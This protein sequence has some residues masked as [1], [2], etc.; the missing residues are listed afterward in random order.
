MLRLQTGMLGT[1][2]C[3]CLMA[4]CSKPSAEAS[5]KLAEV[6]AA[7]PTPT[8]GYTAVEVTGGGTLKGTVTLV[9][10]KPSLPVVRCAKDPEICGKP[11]PSQALLLGPNNALKNV[12]VSL[13]DI[14]AGRAGAAGQ[15]HIDIKKCAYEPR[16]QAV[17]VKSNVMVTN[18]DEIPHD[19]N[20][21]LGSRSLFNRTVL[22]KS[23]I[24][25]LY[26]PGMLT[27]GCDIHGVSGVAPACESGV[28]GVMP[29]P[30]FAVTGEDG[31]FAIPDVPPGNYTLQ[32]WHETLGQQEQR[33]VMGPGATVV[34]DFKWS[35]KPN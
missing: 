31:T 29:N 1:A 9:G 16:V 21:A 11:H 14:H 35:P 28:I 17:P 4:G 25:D 3:A 33:V 13:T 24:V 23:E 10:N 18:Q 34:S 30:Y 20:G 19:F 22:G 32:A 26:T 2:L 8:T 15:A 5:A 27:I 12:I 7:P 6:P